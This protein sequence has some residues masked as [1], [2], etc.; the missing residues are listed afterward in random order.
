[1]PK[2]VFHTPESMWKSDEESTSGEPFYSSIDWKMFTHNYFKFDGR[3]TMCYF[4]I[5]DDLFA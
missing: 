3:D 2:E 1:M 4:E 5:L